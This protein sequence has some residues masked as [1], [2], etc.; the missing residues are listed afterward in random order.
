MSRGNGPGGDRGPHKTREQKEIDSRRENI[1]WELSDTAIGELYK[2][3]N[4]F[5]EN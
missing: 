5:F 2:F 1:K 3:I 4:P